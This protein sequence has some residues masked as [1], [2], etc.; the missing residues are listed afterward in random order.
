MSINNSTYS[1]E[2]NKEK[3]GNNK[4]CLTQ[5]KQQPSNCT[6]YEIPFITRWLKKQRW[7]TYLPFLPPY[8]ERQCRSP[9]CCRSIKNNWIHTLYFILKINDICLKYS[10]NSSFHKL[11]SSDQS[12]NQCVKYFPL[13][14]K[15]CRSVKTIHPLNR[16]CLSR[17]QC[18]KCPTIFSV[19]QT[20]SK[21]IATFCVTPILDSWVRYKCRWFI[22][23][24]ISEE[25]VSELCTVGNYLPNNYNKWRAQLT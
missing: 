14:G 16:D 24:I 5:K 6:T 19:I 13:L 10:L 15:W 11:S 2:E 12:L 3:S 4:K 22:S 20:R 21:Y 7:A 1:Q 18:I 17:M 25:I 23:S 9:I 8:K